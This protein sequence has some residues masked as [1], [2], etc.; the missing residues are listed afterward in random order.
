MGQQ[1]LL[2]HMGSSVGLGSGIA[3]AGGQFVVATVGATK[4]ILVPERSWTTRTPP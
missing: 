4:P 2:T 3:V 1:D